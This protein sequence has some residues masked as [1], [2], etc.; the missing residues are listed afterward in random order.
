MFADCE[1]T[2]I[3][4]G[5]P[6]PRFAGRRSPRQFP[7]Y[8]SLHLAPRGNEGRQIISLPSSVSGAF[9]VRDRSRLHAGA[10]F[11]PQSGAKV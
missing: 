2:V 3:A 7:I 11:S 10:T 8:Q 4:Q 9:F 1:K 6:S 5:K